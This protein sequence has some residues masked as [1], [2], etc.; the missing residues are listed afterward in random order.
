MA[1]T[2]LLNLRTKT[3]KVFDAGGG[4]RRHNFHVGNIHY[5][6]SLNAF[7]DI[8]TT[9][10]T[11][12]GGWYQEKSFYKCEIPSLSDGVFSF[13]NGDHFFDVKLIGTRVGTLNTPVASVSPIPTPD[14]WGAMG[15]GFRYPNC[16]GAGIH[17]EII[18]M[19]MKFEKRVVFDNPPVDVVNDFFVI[20]EILAKPD[21]FEYGDDRNILSPLNIEQIEAN[22]LE[23]D[24]KVVRLRNALG[25]KA[26]YIYRPMGWDSNPLFPIKKPVPIKFFK[27]SGRYYL[28]KKIPAAVWSKIVFPLFI[29]DP[30]RYDPPAGDGFIQHGGTA[31][32]ASQHDDT[33]ATG[34][35]VSYTDTVN[36]VFSYYA[37][38]P[39]YKCARAFVPINLS[40]LSGTVTA[41]DLYLYVTAKTNDDNDGD[42]WINAVGQTTQASTA[43]LVLND[44]DTCGAVSNPTEGATRID[45]GAI[46][47]S[48]Y[49]TWILD[50]TGISWITGAYAMLGIREGHDCINSPVAGVLGAMSRIKFNDSA[51]TGTANDPYLDVTTS[52]GGGLTISLSD[53][54][55]VVENVSN[56]LI[57]VRIKVSVSDAINITEFTKEPITPLIIRLNE[58]I[59]VLENLKAVISPLTISGIETI[60]VIDN[61]IASLST[62]RLNITASDAISVAESI[63][64]ELSGI[65]G[66]TKSVNEAISAI[67]NITVSLLTIRYKVSVS[68]VVSVL[69]N[70][71][72]QLIYILYKI[73]VFDS[74]TVTENVAILLT[75]GFEAKPYNIMSFAID[76]DIS[77]SISFQGNILPIS[78]TTGTPTAAPPSNK[79]VVFKV[80]GGVVTI[81][82]WDGSAWREK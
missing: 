73:T 24:D 69:E 77:K 56:N 40:G 57:T 39:I 62:V 28:A 46:T 38:T 66:L 33:T 49:N 36:E 15:K 67:E 63:S 78:I 7:Q 42:D 13:F 16:L 60:T 18:C 4:V 19:N 74:I 44:Y 22:S 6:D 10:I 5:P 17:F 55:A 61:A 11:R 76:N 25:N 51:M 59:T 54:V 21:T 47:T 82:V 52:G 45:I 30:V 23:L 48:A 64:A 43:S 37:T 20:F 58:A 71:T 79:G 81:F 12:I 50:A 14:I 34:G 2:E 1:E 75:G 32:W 70:L 31:T 41:A 80:L 29:D 35:Y 26:S 3:S 53:S 65:T 72:A 9:L 8:D 68:E 27:R